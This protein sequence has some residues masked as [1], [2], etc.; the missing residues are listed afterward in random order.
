MEL[1]KKFEHRYKFGARI[2]NIRKNGFEDVTILWDSGCFNT[3]IPRYLAEQT[4]RPLGHK[5][6]Y[7]MGARSVEVEA[8]SI[9]KMMIG[10]VL[11]KRVVAF[12]GNYSGDYEDDIILGANVINNWEMIISKKTH[13]FRFREDPPENLP[14]KTH[15]YQNF[16]SKTG[17]YVCIQDEGAED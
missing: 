4:G 2:Y 11:L 7:K 17:S 10:N 9:D 5:T 8:F 13:T 1:S 14:N 16:F 3:M 15:I 6:N 12:A